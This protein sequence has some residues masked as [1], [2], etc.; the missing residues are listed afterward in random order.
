[1]INAAGLSKTYGHAGHSIPALRDISL[2]IDAG[3]RV[4]IVGKSGS[5]KSTLLNLL[6]G[7]D[8]PTSGTLVVDGQNLDQMR[9]GD[10]AHYRCRSVGI[11]FQAFQLLPHLTAVKN[12]ELPLILGRVPRRQR[13]QTAHQWLQRVGLA[14]RADHLPYALS[15]GEQQRV[16][17]AR[18]LVHLPRLLLADEPTGNLDSATA[19][20]IEQLIMELCAE[21]AATFVLVTHDQQLASRC[22]TRHFRMADGTI[23]EYS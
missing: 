6:A 17:I 19:E 9:R 12:I 15:G 20:Q 4:A 21:T 7:L 2:T 22:S 11:V 16:A 14:Q 10:M 3:E 23:S 13:E 5:G 18:A 8:H 1:M